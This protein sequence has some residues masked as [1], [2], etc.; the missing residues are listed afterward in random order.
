VVLFEAIVN[1]VSGTVADRLDVEVGGIV[2]IAPTAQLP[3]AFPVSFS[4]V[5]DGLANVR[6]TE[7]KFPA[8]MFV[9]VVI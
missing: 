9:A 6:V 1:P 4:M 7:V 2:Q 3:I 5:S 8:G